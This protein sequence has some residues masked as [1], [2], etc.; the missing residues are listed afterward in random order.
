MKKQDVLKLAVL[1]ALTIIVYVPAFM[2]MLDNWNGRDTYYSHGFLIPLISIFIIWQKRKALSQLPLKPLNSGWLLFLGGLLIH[3]IS[4]SW[5]VNFTSAFSFILT[6]IGMV[7]LFFG[8]NYLRQLLFPIAFLLFMIP[9]PAVAIVNLSFRLKIFVAQIATLVIN[10]LGVPAIREGS[11]IITMHSRIMVENPCSGI[12]SL[13]ALI[14]LGALMAYYSKLSPAKKAI[15]FISSVPVA[16]S[17]NIIRIIALSMVCEIYGEKYAAGFFHD[18]MGI[19]IFVLAF[20][21]LALI[22]RLLGQYG[23]RRK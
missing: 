9:L 23:K 12:R 7:M 17:T 1:A 10:K 3:I 13:I 8:K 18:A 5:Q 15:L 16:V 11:L 22:A 14:A 4:A 6:L 19:L 21:G 2:W 20:W